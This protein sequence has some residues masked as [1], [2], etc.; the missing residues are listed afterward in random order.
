MTKQSIVKFEFLLPYYLPIEENCQIIRHYEDFASFKFICKK[1]KN[2]SFKTIAETEEFC[3]AIQFEF[4]PKE[5]NS[6]ENSDLMKRALFNG[7]IF[8][9]NFIDCFRLVND[10]DFIKNFSITDLP[11]VIEIEVNGEKN[12]YIT[13]PQALIEDKTPLGTDKIHLTQ[14]RMESWDRNKRVEVI[15]KFLSKAKNHLFRE[16]FLY[17]IIELQTSFESYIRLCHFLIL[18]KNGEDESKIEAAKDYP[19]K[20]TIVDHIGRELGKDLHFER[21]SIVKNWNEKLYILRNQVVHS[22]LSYISGEQAYDAYDSLEEI[23]KYINKLMVDKGY[24]DEGGKVHVSRLNKNIEE[25]VDHDK[26][27]EK[28]KEKGFI[29]E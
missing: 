5:D 26:V 3:T 28:L 20:N 12:L 13:S 16:E 15:D 27:L 21:N 6:T 7:L 18:E 11:P 22:G 1:V 8:M 25:N 23:V 17:A 10:F 19:F 14:S 4:M 29:K 9:N 2:E 24:M